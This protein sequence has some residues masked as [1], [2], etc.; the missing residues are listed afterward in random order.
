MNF[1]FFWQKS[2]NKNQSWANSSYHYENTV[3][4]EVL[5]KFTCIWT[6]HGRKKSSAPTNLIWNWNCK[7]KN[8]V[9]KFKSMYS[10]FL[11]NSK[12]FGLVLLLAHLSYKPTKWIIIIYLNICEI[13]GRMWSYLERSCSGFAT[14]ERLMKYVSFS[15]WAISRV[16]LTW[17]NLS[18]AEVD[19]RFAISFSIDS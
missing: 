6:S 1:P 11:Q 15:F 5:K 18:P 8:Q 4:I 16:D 10:F 2:L 3:I 12:W 13:I 7:E 14:S 19:K 17:W 9:Q